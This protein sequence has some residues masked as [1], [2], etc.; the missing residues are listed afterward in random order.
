MNIKGLLLGSAAALAMG[1]SAQAADLP[2][3]AVSACPAGTLDLDGACLDISGFTR[4]NIEFDN[5]N[6]ADTKD[7]T[8]TTAAELN[9]TASTETELGTLVGFIGLD[10]G[11]IGTTTTGDDQG[12]TVGKAYV[13]LGG[14]IA[15]YTTTLAAAN[16]AGDLTSGKDSGADS[17][18]KADLI[19]YSGS[20]GA[21]N[22]ALSVEEY[23]TGASDVP[24][25]GASVGYDF[26]MGSLG[27]GGTFASVK[28]TDADTATGL[29]SVAA[30]VKAM[31]TDA[32]TLVLRGGFESETAGGVVGSAGTDTDTNNTDWNVLASASFAATE[33]VTL[34]A[35]AAYYSTEAT[36]VV[37]SV[38]WAPVSGFAVIGAA[39]YNS[40]KGAADTTDFL[41]RINRSF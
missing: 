31:P 38:S 36:E 18:Y 2:V 8:W 32:I 23:T 28:T 5:E 17:D 13:Q 21:F 24:A 9:F 29:F 30:S 37:G 15:G 1:A 26:G 41:L 14:F 6:T 12:V 35:T 3:A 27:L 34:A 19:G 16:L 20:A 4:L 11:N 10:G 25:I 39:E 40:A 7:I 33:T 22:Y